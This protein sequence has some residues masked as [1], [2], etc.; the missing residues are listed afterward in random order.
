MVDDQSYP[1]PQHCERVLR[2][3]DVGH[4][5]LDTYAS[6]G[7]TGYARTVDSPGIS[8]VLRALTKNSSGV[9]IHSAVAIP[10]R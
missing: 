3:I 8:N 10:R 4:H 2:V 5:G 7:R 1:P 9:P 6:K